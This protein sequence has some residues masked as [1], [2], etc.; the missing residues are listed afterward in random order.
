MTWHELMVI[1]MMH[2]KKYPLRTSVWATKLIVV[3]HPLLYSIL[4]VPLHFVPG[5]LLD[6]ILLLTMQRPRFLS[7]YQTIDKFSDISRFFS[8]REWTF[9]ND[10]M[11]QL[12]DRIGPSDRVLF[13][14]N[15]MNVQW[16][17]FFHSYIKGIRVYM[18]KDPLSTVETARS[19]M[20]R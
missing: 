13:P 7:I 15:M 12:W 6:L 5:M 4:K 20:K 14:F 18:F 17:P 19:R 8:I 16:L 3:K 2:I 11:T 1:G 9:K 10:N